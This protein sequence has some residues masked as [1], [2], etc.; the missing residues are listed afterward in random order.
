MAGTKD[1]IPA[2]TGGQLDAGS[3]GAE[4]RGFPRIGRRLRVTFLYEENEVPAHTVDVSKTGA[5]FEAPVVPPIH[6][7]ILMVL[8]DWHDPELRLNLKARV[9]RW[10]QTD[11]VGA[12]MFAVEFGDAVTKEVKSMGRFLKEVL[13]I[14]SGL[15][16]VSEDRATGERV[17]TFSFEGVIREGDD[18]VRALQSSLFRSM[19]ELEEAD[20]ILA[21]F[22]KGFVPPHDT[23]RQTAGP[24]EERL[25]TLGAIIPAAP[26]YTTQE[27][28]A[29]DPSSERGPN[30]GAA[31]ANK[32]GGLFSG[33]AKTVAPMASPVPP[34]PGVVVQNASLPVLAQVGT[35]VFPAQAVRMYL[36][37]LKCETD[38]PLPSLYSSITI[39]IPSGS[40]KGD[41]QLIGDVTRVRSRQEGIDGGIFELRF[42]MR[43]DRNHMSAYRNLLERLNVSE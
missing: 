3:G 15:I 42:S 39:K 41:I 23:A 14:D 10:V 33:G 21:G 36:S 32:L 29:V 25:P 7:Q 6:S 8:Q 28:A 11:M 22:G 40:K 38:N 5:L 19:E 30:R 13:G 1:K 9:V 4:R 2:V 24:A 20:S 35:L 12:M 37:G 27:M 34:G 26:V 43:T 31:L 17:Y 16:R 18:R